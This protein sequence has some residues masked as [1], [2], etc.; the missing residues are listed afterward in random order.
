MKGL[1][2][3]IQGR[4][5]SALKREE[6]SF[7][8]IFIQSTHK[9]GASLIRGIMLRF[10]CELSLSFAAAVYEECTH[11]CHKTQGAVQ[12]VS[13]VLIRKFFLAHLQSGACTPEVKFHA[14]NLSYIPGKQSS[15]VNMP[16]IVV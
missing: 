6:I 12:D 2:C 5:Y 9:L 1:Y 10:T 16:G 15:C 7:F 4:N 8:P 14:R 3:I 11:A 13:R